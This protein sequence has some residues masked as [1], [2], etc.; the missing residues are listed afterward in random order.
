HNL[1]GPA[2][3]W[4]VTDSPILLASAKGGRATL[5][6]YLM[7]TNDWQDLATHGVEAYVLRVQAILS[8]SLAL[9][10]RVSV[11]YHTIL[12]RGDSQ[13]GNAG[14]EAHRR[15]ANAR[16]RAWIAAQD[17]RRVRLCDFGDN[18]TIGD[19]ARTAEY[20]IQDG[21]HLNRAGDREA[22][23]ICAASVRA[24]RAD[25]GLQARTGNT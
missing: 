20:M 19:P 17:P 6:H 16:M 23:S 4:A 9:H 25:N 10:P 14:F 22:A 3:R 21:I 2:G 11:M 12:P 7:G 1:E 8:A 18:P 24:W 5:Y 15:D 13:S